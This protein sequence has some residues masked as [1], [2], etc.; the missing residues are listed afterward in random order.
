MKTL[1]EEL[2]KQTIKGEIK[3]HNQRRKTT[4][5]NQHNHNRKKEPTK[6]KKGNTN[7]ETVKKT[8]E[9]SRTPT[10]QQ[11]LKQSKGKQETD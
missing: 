3:W 4:N 9:R 1:K 6:R 5:R 11:K 8:P 10:K 2:N 7:I